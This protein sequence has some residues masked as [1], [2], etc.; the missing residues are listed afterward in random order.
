M[1]SMYE[2]PAVDG[3]IDEVRALIAAGRVEDASRAI[4]GVALYH[5][6]GDAV[7]ALLRDASSHPDE[8]VSGNAVLGFGHIARRGH[9]ISPESIA[10]V[11]RAL[12]S[13]SD[14]VRGQASAAH[15]DIE[16]FQFGIDSSAIEES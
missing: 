15:E 7:E 9:R 16:F 1:P 4:I 12:S 11:E 14:H 8:F 3:F 10:I 13:P 6:D 2:P 5:P